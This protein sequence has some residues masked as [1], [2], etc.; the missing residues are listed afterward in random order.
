MRKTR[1]VREDLSLEPMT[2][3]PLNNTFVSRGHMFQGSQQDKKLIVENFLRELGI[4]AILEDESEEGRAMSIYPAP[5]DFMLNNWTAEDLPV[6]FKSFSKLPIKPE[7]KPVQQKL[8]MMRVEIP[9]KVKVEVKKQLDDGFLK[10]GKY[11][12]WVANIV[13]VL[14]N[15]GKIRICVDYRDLNKANPKDNFP[16]PHIDTLLTEKCDPIFYLLRK[17]N[18]R[19]WSDDFQEAFEAVK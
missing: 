4:N 2:F 15:D 7:F 12:E 18:S 16:L 9:L 19:A 6:V 8:R 1:L 3:P 11:P 5:P 13:P 14:K 10:V 17:N